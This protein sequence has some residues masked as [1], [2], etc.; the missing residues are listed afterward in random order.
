MSKVQI[1]KR[2]DLKTTFFVRQKLDEDYVIQLGELYEAGVDIPPIQ[3]VQGTMEVLDGRHRLRAH[4]LLERDVVPVVFVPDASR[5]DL[6]C[7]AFKS[8]YG[9]PRPPSR[10]DIE[11]TIEQLLAE[12]MGLARLAEKLPFPKSLVRRY[13]SNVQSNLRKRK[14]SQATAAIVDGNMTVAKAAE[15]FGVEVDDLKDVISGKRKKRVGVG[16]LKG[17]VTSRM[18]GT[19][20]KNMSVIRKAFDAYDDG[21]M[22]EKNVRQLLAHIAAAIKQMEKSHHGWEARFDAKVRA[23]REEAKAG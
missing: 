17:N 12:G 4:D 7:E 3:V 23:D 16:D 19:S 13:I 8:N 20:L 15:K 6:L 11:F 21:T 1:V 14:V 2:S 5:A 9:G 10:D 18:R 22:S